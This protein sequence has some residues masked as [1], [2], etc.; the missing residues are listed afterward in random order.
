M[1]SIETAYAAEHIL[2]QYIFRRDITLNPNPSYTKLLSEW[3]Y[4]EEDSTTANITEAGF[5]LGPLADW[6][7]E[8]CAFVNNLIKDPTNGV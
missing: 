4:F 6:Y 7:A 2:L 1:S 5:E 3:E 8:R